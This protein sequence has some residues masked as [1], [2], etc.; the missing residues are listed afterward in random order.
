V[1]RVNAYAITGVVLAFVIFP[2]G[3]LFSIIGLV[4]SK[5]RAGSGKILSIVGIALSLVAAVP[6]GIFV[7][8]VFGSTA[9]PGCVAQ[10]ETLTMDNTFSA[11]ENAAIQDEGTPAERADAQHILGHA[12]TLRSELNVAAAKAQKQSVR[13]EIGMMVSD[14][15]TMMTGARAVL[16]GDDD[17]I[18]QVIIAD[19][20]LIKAN[21]S[22]IPF[23]PQPLL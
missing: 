20:A 3:L 15:G 18:N 11:E 22:L 4:K 14:V 12:Q 19:T 17:Q 5:A 13:A 8:Q 6:F 21:T 9:D 7:V 2:L 1:K 10:S 16:H 23:C